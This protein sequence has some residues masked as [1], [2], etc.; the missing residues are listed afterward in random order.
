MSAT[1]NT[2]VEMEN[3]PSPTFFT[4]ECKTPH[5]EDILNETKSV[6][7]RRCKDKWNQMKAGD[8]ILITCSK[9]IEAPSWETV[10]TLSS[11]ELRHR[12]YGFT[13]FVAKITLVNKYSNLKEYLSTETLSKCLPRAP[14]MDAALKEYETLFP[15]QGDL[16]FVGLHLSVLKVKDLMIFDSI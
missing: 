5:F 3:S 12:G 4:G 10:K 13:F 16:Q 1:S 7:G 8:Y 11:L 14:S 9:K 15:E 2:K 6:E